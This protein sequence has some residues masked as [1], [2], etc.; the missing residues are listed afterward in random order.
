MA[1]INTERPEKPRLAWCLGVCGVYRRGCCVTDGGRR[2]RREHDGLLRPLGAEPCGVKLAPKRCHREC[3][4]PVPAGEAVALAPEPVF[5]LLLGDDAA[6]GV[7][8]FFRGVLVVPVGFADH[9]CPRE[10]EVDAVIEAFA[11]EPPLKLGCL[12]A[13]PFDDRATDRFRGRL[14]LRI[15]AVHRPQRLRAAARVR[16]R[17][18]ERAEMSPTRRVREGWRDRRV[19]DRE[20]E[21][22][23]EH[24]KQI[25]RGVGNR[26]DADHTAADHLRVFARVD[27]DIAEAPGARPV[28]VVGVD[29]ARLPEDRQAEQRRG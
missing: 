2:E 5:A 10:E 28:G 14:G 29:V 8:G 7:S 24:A 22:R 18:R 13:R 12:E 1:P 19:G 23:R 21:G 11:R 25:E 3:V 6:H 26:G 4:G 9:P 20:C 16:C 17:L 27:D 15:C